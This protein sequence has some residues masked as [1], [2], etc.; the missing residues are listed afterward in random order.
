MHITTARDMVYLEADRWEQLILSYIPCL[1]IFDF[2]HTIK[3]YLD[4]PEDVFET[5][6]CHFNSSFWHQRQWFFAHD[7]YSG[8]Y[9]EGIFYSIQPYR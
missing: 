4:Y 7:P 2:K 9:L 3:N 6:F 1:R 8:E 5:L